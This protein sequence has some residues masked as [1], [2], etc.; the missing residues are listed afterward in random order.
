[1]SSTSWRNQHSE[2]PE[3]NGHSSTSLTVLQKAIV[4]GHIAIFCELLNQGADVNA[5]CKDY[6]SALGI[7][8]QCE[9]LGMLQLLLNKNADLTKR[10]RK[11]R[12]ILWRAVHKRRKDLVRILLEHGVETEEQALAEAKYYGDAEIIALLKT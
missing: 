9:Q 5:T 11:D 6:G 8:V 1:M 4:Y 2:C 12:N 3:E 10:D 7:A